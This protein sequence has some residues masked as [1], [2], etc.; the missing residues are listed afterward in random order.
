MPPTS[1]PSSTTTASAVTIPEKPES[2]LDL[3][4]ELTEL[5]CR[6]YEDIIGKDLVGYIQEFV[7]PKTEASDATAY[8]A[9]VPPYTYGSHKS[10]LI[11]VLRGAL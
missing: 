10:R 9:A 4:G 8:A 11:A 5:F 6:S 7:G 1:S 3:T 2:K